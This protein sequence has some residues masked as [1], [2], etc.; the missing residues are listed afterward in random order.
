MGHTQ[1]Q[2]KYC[3]FAAI[4]LLTASL[5]RLPVGMGLLR[6]QFQLLAESGVI[7][8]FAFYLF[9]TNKWLGLFLVLTVVSSIYPVFGKWSYM[10]RNSIVFGLL[11]FA[12]L[13][14]VR[15]TRYIL[16]ALCVIAIVHTLFAVIQFKGG[17]PYSIFTFG[18][19]T[20]GTA[21]PVGLMANKNILSA[22]LAFC[23]PAFLRPKWIWV[24]FIPLA[25]LY[26]ADSLGGTVAVLAG[27][28]FYLMFFLKR[29]NALIAIGVSVVCAIIAVK[30]DTNLLLSLQDRL[31][32]WHQGYLLF[33]QNWILGCGI[34]H[35][36]LIMKG[37]SATPT[38]HQ[39]HNEFIQVVMEMGAIVIP[40]FMGYFIGLFR[41]FSKK[42]LLPATALVIIIINSL[43][44]FPF[45]IGTTALVAVTWMA[46]FQKEAVCS[47]RLS[48]LWSY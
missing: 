11:W 26:V 41:G 22:L 18:L 39:L 5:F 3:K 40:I 16:D 29:R 17:D 43:V 27:I 20:S 9:K 6:G 28:L 48:S 34:G 25:G 14:R 32:A 4:L 21:H 7:L 2:G 44:N 45:H 24:S 1:L 12:L 38:F 35:A 42:N 15:D 37:L 8:L 46:L 47:K 13:L 10:T 19:I 23:F 36:K 33:K 31:G 30:S